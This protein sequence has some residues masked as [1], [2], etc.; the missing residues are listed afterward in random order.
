MTSIII[1]ITSFV[2]VSMNGRCVIV[3][4]MHSY[5][6]TQ[7]SFK[8]GH[9]TCGINGQFYVL[10]QSVMAQHCRPCIYLLLLHFLSFYGYSVN[11]RN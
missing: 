11:S 6:A 9:K 4:H 7:I 10:L 3:D 1:C 8:G 2:Q 5:I